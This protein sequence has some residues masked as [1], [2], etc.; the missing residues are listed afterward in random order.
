MLKGA[1][2]DHLELV[3]GFS[4]AGVGLRFTKASGPLLELGSIALDGIAVHVY[5]EA[6]PHGVGGGAKVQLDGLA[7]APGGGNGSGVANNIMNDVG[8]ASANNRPRNR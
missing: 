5:A 6:G 7:V 8:T 3:P 1:D 2:L 4:V